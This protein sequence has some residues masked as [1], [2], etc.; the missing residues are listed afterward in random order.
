MDGV[1]IRSL[2]AVSIAGILVLALWVR[3]SRTDSAPVSSVAAAERNTSPI[4]EHSAVLEARSD[5]RS[6][7]SSLAEVPPELIEPPA[8]NIEAALSGM[9]LDPAGVPIF[10]SWSSG[11]ALMDAKG[12]KRYSDARE[13]G[14]Y[15]F[16][17]LPLGSYSLI[18]DAH[19][20]LRVEDTLELGASRPVL[21]KDITLV[22]QPKIRIRA[23]TPEGQSLQEALGSAHRPAGIL[24]PVAT[25]EDPG[26]RFDEVRGSLNNPF[27][28][29]TFWNYGPPVESLTAEYLGVVYL[30]CELPVHVSL[31]HYHHVLRTVEVPPGEDEVTFV[32]SVEDLLADLATLRFRVE[33]ELTGRGIP[34]GSCFLNGPVLARHK[35]GPEGIVAIEGIAPGRYSLRVAAKG[36]E[37]LNLSVQAKPGIMDLGALRL[38]RAVRVLVHVVEVDGT[39]SRAK[40]FLRV[41]DPE[42]RR[43]VDRDDT[44][45]YGC[46][47]AGELELTQ[48]GRKLYCLQVAPNGPPDDEPGGSPNWVSENVLLDTRNGPIA[49]VEVVLRPAARLVLR[50][51]EANTQSS[52]FQIYDERDLWV[53]GS[54]FYDR[55]PRPLE[56]APGKY[57]V[58]VCDLDGKELSSRSVTVDSEP[59]VLELSR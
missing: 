39:P 28:V 11:V 8:S 17:G 14:R 35:I 7:R 32:L 44:F 19:G 21:E 25:R 46:E 10:G 49:D 20:Y 9:L 3:G 36:F 47:R 2:V 55:S 40:F 27:G 50:L 59:T 13:S 31:V 54:R 48:L 23:I 41:L 5:P 42:T 56:L 52:T 57:R 29:G 58:A 26:D 51:D 38:V 30:R 18:A 22:P 33:D 15:G 34:D 1:R 45:R 12:F 24:V 4:L 53:M 43:V 16:Q 6:N 37:T